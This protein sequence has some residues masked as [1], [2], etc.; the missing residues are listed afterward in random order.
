MKKKAQHADIRKH[1]AFLLLGFIFFQ[2]AHKNKRINKKL[3]SA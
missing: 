1:F 2:T 3:K